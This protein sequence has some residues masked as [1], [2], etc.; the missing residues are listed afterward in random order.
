ME[1]CGHEQQTPYC[2]YCGQRLLT[3]LEKS[4]EH[5]KKRRRRHELNMHK[6]ERGGREY[7]GYHAKANYEKW[8]RY[9]KALEEA[10][11]KASNQKSLI[12]NQ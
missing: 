6:Q 2:A 7:I 1:C 11:E 12:H 4:L 3:Q 8:D 5:C 10:I 9:C